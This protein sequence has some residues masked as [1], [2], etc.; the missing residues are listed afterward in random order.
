MESQK[1][2]LEQIEQKKTEFKSESYPMSIG[3]LTSLYEKN[4]LIINPDFQRYFR[5]TDTQKTKLIESI[6]LGIPI[7]TI[8]VFQREDGIWELVD[9][10]QRV[11]TLLQFMGLHPTKPRLVLQSTKYLPRL[12][13]AVW[14]SSEEGEFELPSS[15]KLFIK[16]AKVN[17]TI[18]LS[19]TGKTAKFEV[20]QR[21]NTGGTLA[22]PQEVRNSLMI[23]TNKPVYEWLNNLAKDKDFLDSISVSDRLIEE[24]YPMEL[25]LRHI[26]LLHYEY[27]PKKE[28]SDFFDDVTEK[29]I[30]EDF[31]LT[32]YAS[33]FCSTFKL[34][35]ELLGEDSFKKFD[36]TKFKGKFLE[37]AFEAV[38]I[39]IAHNYQTYSLPADNQM[40]IGK[41]Q[42]LHNELDF[43]TYTGSGG[44]ARTRIPKVIPFAK[45]YFKK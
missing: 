26:A 44:N 30:T 1:I 28:L 2:L 13:G 5:W 29:M 17:L 22:S 14:E 31:D 37:S 33:S 20:F 10:L 24:Q 32:Q 23:M 36:G 38:S 39:G 8:F 25:A 9:G 34:L 45:E 19:D 3:E 7:P 16:R 27:T 6:L 21:L 12:E 4:E 11:S 40:I 18:I 35:N 15:L 43:V 41:I 42:K